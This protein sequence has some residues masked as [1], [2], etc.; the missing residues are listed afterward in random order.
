MELELSYF[1]NLSR[2]SHATKRDFLFLKYRSLQAYV[3][4][5]FE[6]SC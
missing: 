5:S 1:L 2:G 6:S 4:A 3:E